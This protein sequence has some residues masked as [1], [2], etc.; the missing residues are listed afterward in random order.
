MW[1]KL[2]SLNQ[3]LEL[4]IPEGPYQG[5]YYSHLLSMEDSY[6]SISIPISKGEIVPIRNGTPLSVIFVGPEAMYQ[7]ESRVLKRKRGKVPSLLISLPENFR[8]IQRREF[9]R[10]KVNIPLLFRKQEGGEDFFEA[11]TLDLSGG[12][13]KFRAEEELEVGETVLVRFKEEE[14]TGLDLEAEI[15]RREKD[16]QKFIYAARFK[17]IPEREQDEIIRFIFDKQR[18]LKKKGL[19]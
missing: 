6:L 14:L 2:L 9:F 8:R 1:Q 13:C 18:K 17:E 12:G 16:D 11:F 4:E 5:S 15:L 3:R 19:L 10:L 7:F